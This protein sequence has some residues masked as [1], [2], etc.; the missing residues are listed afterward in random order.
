MLSIIKHH[1]H[2]HSTN[3]VVPQ[4]R[5]PRQL[6]PRRR[7][8]A[9]HVAGVVAANPRSGNELGIC[10]FDTTRRVELTEGGAKFRNIAAKIVDQAILQTLYARNSLRR[11]CRDRQL[12][13]IRRATIV[14][15][16]EPPAGNIAINPDPHRV[17]VKQIVSEKHRNDFS[18]D[19]RPRR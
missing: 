11:I 14:R 8:N 1:E 17:R 6:H 18:E 19:D 15:A 12:D 5:R 7:E 9:H 4:R 10:L 16:A 13:A 3:P 2:H